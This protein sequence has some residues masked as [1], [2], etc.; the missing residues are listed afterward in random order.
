M[1][2]PIRYI[3]ELG[4][5]FEDVQLANVFPDNKTF[6]DCT[7]KGINNEESLLEIKTR[8]AEQKNLSEFDLRRFVLNN[9]DLPQ[10]HETSYKTDKT[11]SAKEHIEE[12]WTILTR[13]PHNEKSSLIPLPN[14]YIV[15]GG[16][17]GEVY[18]W[19]SYF[20][21]L[22]LQESNR[23]DMIQAMVDNFSYLIYKIGHIPNANRIYYI[24]RSQPPFYAL[25]LRLLSE[26][27]GGKVM[28][29]YLP[30]LE[31]EYEFWMEGKRL[32][33][34]DTKA[35]K[36]V[37]KM[38]DGEVLNRY[39]DN[40]CTPR[41][42]AFKEDFE[43]AKNSKQRPEELYRNLRAAAESGWDF[44]SRWF[45]NPDAFDS[46]HTTDIIPIDLNCLLV[47]L[48]ETIAEVYDSQ[49][50]TVTAK[51]YK[52][53][54]KSRRE[55]IQK[56]CW[57]KEKGFYFDYDFILNAQK[58]HQ[59]LASTYPLFFSLATPEQAHKIKQT[60]EE[61]FLKTGGLVTTLAFTGQ[62][63][64]APNGWAPL[65]WIA[66]KGLKNYGF[67]KLAHE[68]KTR[69][70]KLNLKVYKDSGKMTEKYNVNDKDIEAGGGEYPNQ[71]G[72]GWTNGV[73]L[74][75]MVE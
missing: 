28:V 31:K 12:L 74:K 47:Y 30:Y 75:M 42:E 51:K 68:I 59:T 36:R 33:K 20:T 35:V 39:W 45:R 11:E 72:F 61:K 65:Q 46:I 66:Y 22:G 49:K 44:S 63:W 27:K 70:L 56:Y 48:E 69:W 54:A 38:K 64:D 57:N 18:Y 71:D 5:L 60:L 1:K 21:M 67:G 4:E 73:L 10:G 9:F 26:V 55:A 23:I 52:I 62:Q 50:S 2:Q 41:P 19:D 14:P 53:L 3:H 16:R 32:I 40:H 25:M 29:D 37:V 43:L 34:G 15:P 58:E 7:P 13:E 17:F 24:G 6:P 8:Y